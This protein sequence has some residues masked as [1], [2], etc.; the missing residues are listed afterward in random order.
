MKKMN[1]QKHPIILHNSPSGAVE[2]VIYA[3]LEK[4]AKQI[5]KDGKRATISTLVGTHTSEINSS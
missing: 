2:R 4:F 3:L 5:I 1:E